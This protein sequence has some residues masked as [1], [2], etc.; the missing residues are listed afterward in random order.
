MCF[1]HG[2]TWL[3]SCMAVNAKLGCIFDGRKKTPPKDVEVL[4]FHDE[5][6]AWAIGIFDGRKYIS[7]W[8]S[9]VLY[10]MLVPPRSLLRLN[11]LTSVCKP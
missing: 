5:V 6:F 7:K 3:H 4:I 11:Q 8:D 2:L 9:A 1:G 10:W